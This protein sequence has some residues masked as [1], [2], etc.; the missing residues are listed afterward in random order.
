MIKT[1]I[2]AHADCGKQYAW[3]KYKI[4]P[5]TTELVAQESAYQSELM[6][7]KEIKIRI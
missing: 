7:G 6:S 5:T 2:D 4:T 1:Q 3:L